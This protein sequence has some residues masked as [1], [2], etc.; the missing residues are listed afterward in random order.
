MR[1]STPISPF[2]VFL[3]NSISHFTPK[4]LFPSLCPLQPA[5]YCKNATKPSD[6]TGYEVELFRKIMPYMGWTDEMIEW[7]CMDW[8]AM[9]QDLYNS[10]TCDLAPTGMT[11]SVERQDLGLRFSTTSLRSGFSIMVSRVQEAPG[12]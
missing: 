6:F 7:K 3:W 10:T 4:T 11:P 12:R 5:V 2:S 1:C 9:E 8:D